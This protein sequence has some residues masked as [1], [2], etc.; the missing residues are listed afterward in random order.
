M[1]PSKCELASKE[2][3]Y[4]VYIL[5]VEGVKMHPAKIEVISTWKSPKSVK[6]IRSSPSFAYFYRGFIKDFAS[7]SSL[8][9]ALTKKGTTFFWNPNHQSSFEKIN[10]FI[11]APILRIWLEDRV[12]ILETGASRWATDGQQVVANHITART[13]TNTQLRISLKN[14]L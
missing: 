9:H 13:V 7:I 5:N 6:E 4:L 14:L 12:T 2:I 11:P 3:K 8:L 1:D 10:L